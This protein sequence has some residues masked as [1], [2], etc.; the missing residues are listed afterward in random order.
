MHLTDIVA[1]LGLLILKRLPPKV[2]ISKTD[3]FYY[4]TSTYVIEGRHNVAHCAVPICVSVYPA[5]IVLTTFGRRLHDSR[6]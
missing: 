2:F 3:L 5:L 6:N 4:K 1:R